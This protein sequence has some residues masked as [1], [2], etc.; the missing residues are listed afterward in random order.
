MLCEL[1]TE[2]HVY[3]PTLD[4]KMF[5][6]HSIT[7]PIEA[8]VHVFGTF[9]LVV[10]FMIPYAVE[11]SVMISVAS[12]GWPISFRVVLSASNSDY[13]IMLYILPPPLTTLR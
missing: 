10:P 2:V 4:I 3:W 6:F 5:L 7:Y 13:I 9:C 11:F 8:Q 1:I 12:C